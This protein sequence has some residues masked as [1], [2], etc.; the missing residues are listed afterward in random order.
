MVPDAAA[1]LY[2]PRGSVHFVRD[3]RRIL[4]RFERHWML[5]TPEQLVDIGNML[6]HMLVC[7][8]G[9][10]YL[11]GG[12]RLRALGGDHTLPLDRSSASELRDLVNDALL[13]FEAELVAA[14]A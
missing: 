5:F 8:M 14:T 7:P 11:A 3:T 10:H 1:A 2:S 13:L 9:D 6:A 4:V 12:M